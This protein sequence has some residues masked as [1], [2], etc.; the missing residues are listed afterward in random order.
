MSAPS[1]LTKHIDYE[2]LTFEND[3]FH[4]SVYRGSPT[5]EL[6]KAWDE[7]WNYGAFNVPE[8]MVPGFNKSSTGLR[9]VPEEKGGGV[10][11]LLEGSHQIHCLV[12]LVP[13]YT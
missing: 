8:K 3:F 6:E 10:A 4:E 13:K 12:G 7:L 11:G 9:R 2:W 1:P 5:P